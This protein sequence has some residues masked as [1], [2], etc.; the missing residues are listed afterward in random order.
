MPNQKTQIINGLVGRRYSELMNKAD[1]LIKIQ[2]LVN[3][4]LVAQTELLQK[5]DAFIRTVLDGQY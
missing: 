3:E 2:K 4:G 5:K 1:E